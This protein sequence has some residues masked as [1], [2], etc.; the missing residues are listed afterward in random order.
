MKLSI[1][2]IGDEI[3]LGQV[4]DTNS[5]EIARSLI[6]LGWDIVEIRVVGD[7]FEA[8]S[9]AV[10]ECLSKSDLVIT[11]GGLGPTKDDITKKVLLNYFGGEMIEDSD[12]LE[13]VKLIF[14]K[15]GLTLNALTK[16]QAMVPSSCRIIQ[17]DFGTAPIMWFEKDGKTLVSMPGVPFECVGMLHKTVIHEIKEKFSKRESFLHHT[18]I[19]RGIT[20]SSLAELLNNFETELPDNIHLAYLPNPGYIRL[21]LDAV[22]D[23]EAPAKHKIFEKWVTELKS[24][25]GSYLVH[26]GDA[27]PSEILL[28]RLRRNNFTIATAESCTGGNIARSITAIAGCSD[29]FLGGVVSYANSVKTNVLGVNHIDIESFG[30]VSETVVRQMADG[31]ARLT[32]S[33]C[34]IATSGIAGPG[35]AVPQKPVGTVWVA[36]HT[37]TCTKTKLLHLNG[38]RHLIIERA[39]T[40]AILFLI[41]S[42]D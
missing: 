9:K 20:E 13:N 4:T 32:D 38:N 2:I 24:Q 35:G 22:F 29:S 6:P 41:D 19:V 28:D 5:G 37:P 33:D 34:A 27:Y 10:S 25:I 7:T 16:T 17:N 31:V 42:I 18:L 8:I 26:D 11:T 3:L 14:K 40:E 21:R 39:T 12:V 1:I 15:R 23:E 30:A 36:V